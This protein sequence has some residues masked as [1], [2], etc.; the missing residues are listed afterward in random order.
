[1]QLK[2]LHE[3]VLVVSTVQGPSDPIKLA[4][5]YAYV[6]ELQDDKVFTHPLPVVRHPDRNF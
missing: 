6:Y 2:A 4:H 5:V 3:V 1:M